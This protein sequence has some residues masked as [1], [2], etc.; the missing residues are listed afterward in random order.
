M[1]MEHAEILHRCFRCGYCKFPK[2]YADINC[3][4]YL[5]Y[6]F[7]TFA[8]G[9]RMWLLRALL[10][11]K[12]NGSKRMQKILFSCA[13]CGNCV[14]HCAFPG[15]RD[16]LLDAFTAGKELL[17]DSG[18]IPPEA[19]DYL[20]NLTNHKNPYKKPAKKRGEWAQDLDIPL[21]SDEEYL[22]F[23]GDVGS[24][25]SRGMEI[26]GAAA[27]LL[28]AAGISFGI[29]GGD[30][31][32]DGND[33]HAM[34]ETALFRELAEK[35]IRIWRE[36]GIKKIICL[37]PHGYN[38]IKNLYSPYADDLMVFHYS[39]IVL[40]VLGKLN[41]QE[42]KPVSVTYHDPCYLGR[43]NSDYETVRGI[44]RS[45]PGVQVK[46]MD[47]NRKNALCCGGGGGNFFTDILGGGPES[48]A[49]ARARE[50][51]DTDAQI[52]VTSCPICT[53]ML[54]D[55]VKAGNLDSHIRV[56]EL[57]VFIRER[58]GAIG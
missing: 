36:K 8:P 52:L 19:R 54:E 29:L 25:D 35:N 6:R 38:A 34:G 15:F 10:D 53:T 37:S 18:A 22:F 51:A 55:G 12:I 27:G 5:K 40:Q 32:S 9:G 24:F 41:F 7:E 14:N 23:A 39:A 42:V 47:R 31:Y 30:E 48:A 21:Y 4:A 16:R 57:S 43:H 11:G 17:I 2:N 13:T 46:E 49:A 33:A 58:T 44:L 50:A 26:A 45:I 56:V 20:T 28:K 3:P 1:E